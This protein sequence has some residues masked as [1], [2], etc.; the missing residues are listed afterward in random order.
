MA[1]DIPA[2]GSAI[3]SVLDTAG[4]VNV[5]WA[6]AP[7]GGTPPYCIFNRQAAADGYTFSSH[8]VTADYLVKVISNR[9]WPSE[10]AQIYS[11]LHAA[12]QDAA[13]TV[14]GYTALRCRRTAT[15][16]YMDSEHYWHVGGIYR[17]EI[18]E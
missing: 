4:T 5:Y 10:A 16:E 2:L 8:N 6:L 9:Q 1:N 11:H 3:N 14:T 15:L 7:Q 13:L 12:I 17:V 18:V